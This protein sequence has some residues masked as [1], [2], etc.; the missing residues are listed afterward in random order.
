MV[1][2]VCEIGEREEGEKGDFVRVS[3]ISVSMCRIGL[4]FPFAF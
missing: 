4:G 3:A 2:G 1:I